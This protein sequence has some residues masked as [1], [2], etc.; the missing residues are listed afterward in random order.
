MKFDVGRFGADYAYT[1]DGGEIGELEFENFNA[2]SAKI[3]IQGRNVH[4]GYAKGKMKNAILIAT[5]LN[6][7]LPVQQRPEF[8]EGYEGFFHV[9]GFSGTVEEADVTYIIRDHDRAEFERKKELLLGCVDFI[10]AKFGEGTAVARSRIST[11]TCAGRS[12]RTTMWW[13]R[14]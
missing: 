11:T 6:G 9:V 4:P 10:S 8:T 14:P 13:R 2:A 3:H 12:S 5:E 1:M 7:L